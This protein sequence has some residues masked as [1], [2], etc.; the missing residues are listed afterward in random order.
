MSDLKYKGNPLGSG[1]ITLETPNTNTDRTL[2]LPDAAGEILLKDGDG[3]QLTGIVTPDNTPA[4]EAYS[5]TSTV[6]ASVWAKV[7]FDLEVFDTDNL[8]DAVTSHGF[9]PTAAG[10][11]FLATNI[12]FAQIDSD[13]I[14]QVGIAKNG[15][16]MGVNYFYP[17]NPG[18]TGGA[19][20]NGMPFS[21]IADAA[22]GDTFEV[23]VHQTSGTRTIASGTGTYSSNFYGFKVAG[24]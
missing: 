3:S 18:G 15:T 12:Q 11:Y 6:A 10:K 7:Q 1:T 17:H 16:V 8:F 20:I 19:H 21:I 23:Y 22:A 14:C 13:T 2:T 4:F 24:A 9:T 5:T